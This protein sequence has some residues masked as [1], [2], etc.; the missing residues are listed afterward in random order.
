MRRLLLGAWVS[1][2]S[3]ETEMDPECLTSPFWPKDKRES[4][5]F[6]RELGKFQAS[7]KARLT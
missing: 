2:S 1:H 7:P 3:S 5:H 4:I 6:G